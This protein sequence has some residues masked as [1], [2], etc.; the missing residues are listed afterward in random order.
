MK[1][2]FNIEN[3]AVILF[4]LIVLAIIFWPILFGDKALPSGNNLVVHYPAF[5]FF[6]KA[7][8]VPNMSWLWSGGYLSG[9][10][11]YLSQLGFFHPLNIFYKFFNYFTVYNWLI[12]LNFFFGL[13]ATYVLARN[14]KLSK[15]SSLVAAFAYVLPQWS[16]EIGGTGQLNGFS[17]VISILP[18]LFLSIL[19]ISQGR[20]IYIIIATLLLSIGWLSGFSQSVFYIAI[21]CFLS[22]IFLDYLNYNKKIR[23]WRSW[24]SLKIFFIAVIISL[25]IASPWLL[26][27]GQ[28]IK[29][30]D[31]GAGLTFHQSIVN[32][33][34]IG[35]FIRFFYPHFT[36]RYLVGQ[37]WLFI[38]VLA[39]LLAIIPFLL[40]K[41][42]RAIKL[43]IFLVII[44][45]LFS[46]KYS[47]IVW[48][49]A[50]LPFFNMFR[51]PQKWLL[52]GN[53]ALAILAGFGLDYLAKIKE[54]LRFKKYIK[55]LK[56]FVLLAL[57]LTLIANFIVLVF[58][59]K[60]M[61][62][63]KWFF[64][65]YLYFKTSQAPIEHYH[66]IIGDIFD[67][68][69]RIISLTNPKFLIALIFALISVGFLVLYQKDRFRIL[70]SKFKLIALIIIV[71]NLVFVCKLEKNI[72]ERILVELP[73]VGQFLQSQKS[74]KEGFRVHRFMPSLS[75]IEYAELGLDNL[76]NLD[77]NP[78]LE[79]KF[80]LAT[81]RANINVLFNI[82][83]LGGDEPFQTRRYSRMLQLV[84]GRSSTLAL[85]L[86]EDLLVQEKFK[87]FQSERNRN[88]LSM[89]NVRYII[90][91]FEFPSPWTKVFEA[92]VTDKNIEI[93]IY[94][95]E[96]PDVLSRVYFA[97]KVIFIESDEE[98]AFDFLLENEDFRKTSLIECLDCQDYQSINKDDRI[99]IEE[100][101]SGYLKLKTETSSPRWLIYSESHLP[102]WEAKVNNKLTKIYTAN[103][104]YQAILVPEG[105]NEIEF[106]YPGPFKQFSYSLKN[107]WQRH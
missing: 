91:P 55:I 32:S 11:I 81:L 20:K 48:L 96:N 33:L 68:T 9:F 7:L 44:T 97:N 39:F 28:F 6:S 8:Q 102:T 34:D 35:S 38:S 75:P 59:D 90:S 86:F 84:G 82:D 76:R 13:L 49:M 36:F 27:A 58:R 99:I 52:I 42:N 71:L 62:L 66:Q 2:Y 31:R 50:W 88:L 107:L 65:K 74:E 53:F 80:K 45:F 51:F 85:E 78:E 40:P 64:D 3:L 100:I 16:P 77:I 70:I 93:P 61:N 25:V 89:T 43:F 103:Y 54:H 37:P 57:I 83:F 24:P 79:D 87:I 67:Q 72:P 22:A 10:P 18:L 63:A 23:F 21:A 69:A 12:F 15:I 101:K 106:K 4:F 73:P 104:L 41:K 105:E 1:K 46:F 26:P 17:N 98:R 14:L 56:I 19:K 47:P 95:Y 29:Y 30:T 60:V 92:S 5:A 94:I